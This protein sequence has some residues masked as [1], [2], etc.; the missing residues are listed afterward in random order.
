MSDSS[1]IAPAT[2]GQLVALVVAALMCVG[3]VA[4]ATT[5]ASLDRSLLSATVWQTAFGRQAIFAVL[6]LAAMFAVG[7]GPGV[8]LLGDPRR[9]RWAAW[10]GLALAA[11]L[12]ALVLI[13]G[14]STAAGGSRRWLRLSV[15][16]VDLGIQPSEIVKLALVFW[17]AMWLSTRE[18]LRRSLTG[19]FGPAAVLIG[20]FVAL[21]GVEDFGTAA[22]IAAVCGLMLL[23]GGCSL[24]HLTGSA[25][26]GAGG[27]AVLLFRE[28]YRINRLTAFW[29]PWADPQGLGYHSIQ[30]LATISSGGW[31]GRGLGAGIQKYGYLPE[32]RTDF[33]FSVICEET[34]V[35]GGVIVIALFAAL[36]IAGLFVMLHARSPFER[37]LT[38]GLTMTIVL[39][40]AM[41]L[42][43]VTVCAPTKGISLP[44]ISAGGSGMVVFCA[45]CGLLVAVARRSQ[46]GEADV[47]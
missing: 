26:L 4:V 18:S 22:L 36:A 47:A 25:V 14:M 15:A 24:V 3:L 39:Q 28:T 33:I 19:V 2:R 43:V 5:N 32:A 10:L 46:V 9:V 37:L 23:V 20:G 21:V 45:A 12:S 34:G 13:P 40:A 31:F 30:S 7:Y 38:F 44:F 29:D 17:L 42:A 11:A 6:G 16:G 8:W 35:F 27:F 1:A 41:N